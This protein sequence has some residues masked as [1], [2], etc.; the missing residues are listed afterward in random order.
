[1]T[2]DALAGVET[3]FYPGGR[4]DQRP[5]TLEPGLGEGPDQVVDSLEV[6]SARLHNSWARLSE[7]EWA[8]PICEPPDN[9]DLGE[10]TVAELALLRLT[11]VEVHGCDLD[12]GLGDWSDVF[13]TNALRFRI[14]QLCSRRS[15]KRA[16]VS[17]VE[18]SWMLAATDGPSWR[19]SLRGEEVT[20]EPVDG[21]A[22][23]DAVIEATSRDLLA[24]LLGRPLKDGLVERGD[25]RFAAEFSRA[26]PGP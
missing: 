16:A 4:S 21:P 15:K 25:T 23:A 7:T 5:G 11:E 26:F 9:P 6:K 22:P 19:I 17:G 13:V 2:A 1:M 18:G 20:C 10:T 3:S 14:G 24:L 8:T 12:L